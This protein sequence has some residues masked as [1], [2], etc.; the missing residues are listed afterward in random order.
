MTTPTIDQRIIT[1]SLLSVQS[2]GL[3]LPVLTTKDTDA[4]GSTVD[5]C[6]MTIEGSSRKGTLCWDSVIRA[7]LGVNVRFCLF[8]IVLS[9]LALFAFLAI[10]MTAAYNGD[11]QDDLQAL[12]V[13][14]NVM[15][16]DSIYEEIQPTERNNY[17]IFY[18]ASLI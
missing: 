13:N 16:N 3:L 9:S 4:V 7:A 2:K 15:F 8:A 17:F 18:C 6:S 1:K 10:F 12:H 11:L 5:R 14:G